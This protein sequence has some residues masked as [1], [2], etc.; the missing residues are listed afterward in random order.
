MSN[1]RS[2][3]A[4]CSI[5]MGIRGIHISSADGAI[6]S[7]RQE[8]YPT[9]AARGLDRGERT[10]QPVCI[11][12]PLAHPPVPCASS[13]LARAATR[14]GGE[15]PARRISGSLRCA[16]AALSIRNFFDLSRGGKEIKRHFL[17]QAAARHALDRGFAERFAQARG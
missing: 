15:G 17:A 10:R 11:S 13:A 5:T 9:T 12:A 8:Q 16:F 4:L 1:E 6:R 3:R 2:P 7:T 14:L